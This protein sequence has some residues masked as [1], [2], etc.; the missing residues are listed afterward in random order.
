MGP[1]G[2]LGEDPIPAGALLERMRATQFEVLRGALDSL[3]EE[4]ML[5]LE[6]AARGVSAE[7]LVRAEV[8]SQISLPDAEEIARFYEL[9]KDAMQGRTLEQMRPQISAF[10]QQQKFAR[11]RS[12]YLAELKQ[13]YGFRSLLEPPRVAI[14]LPP[15]VPV[16]GADDAPVTIV[17]FADFQCPACR[18]AYPGLERLLTEYG[19]RIRYVFR[20]FPLPIHPRAIPA[21]E[22]AL[23]ANVQGRYW[24]FY[25]NLMVMEGDLEDADLAARAKSVGLDVEQF[26]ECYRSH[27]FAPDVQAAFQQGRALGVDSTPTFYIN[28]RQI[29]GVQQ[30]E[31]LKEIVDEELAR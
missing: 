12:E 1:V 19:D 21:S 20:D 30:Y 9:R 11:R 6:A 26:N 2:Y 3:A 22:A 28:G 5:Q 31:T 24:D 29:V 4:R 10:L 15:N 14:D 17:E 13:K 7:D 8:T 16:R 18:S 23:C 25:Q 27:R